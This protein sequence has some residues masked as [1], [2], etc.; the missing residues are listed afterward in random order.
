[1]LENL[2]AQPQDAL[3]DALRMQALEA[4]M[5]TLRAQSLKNQASLLELS[6]QLQRAADSRFSNTLVYALLAL[7][8]AVPPL[9]TVPLEVWYR[10]R[11]LLSAPVA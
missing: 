8:A 6:A 7:L 3:H 4:D 1:M 5:N 11:R 2:N 10:R 9:V